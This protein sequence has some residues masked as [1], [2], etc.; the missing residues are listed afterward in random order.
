MEIYVDLRCFQD[1][2]YAFRGVGY[3]SSTLLREGRKFFPADTRWIGIVDSSLSDI[4][5]EYRDLVDELTSVASSEN[6]SAADVFIQLSPMTHSA[7]RVIRFLSRPE[8]LSAVVIYDFIPLDL[9]ERYLT[10]TRLATEYASNLGWLGKYDLMFPISEYSASR[11]MDLLGVDRRNVNVT[12]VALRQVFQAILENG[13]PDDE[14]AAAI[15]SP[16]FLF[17]GG[18]D[19]R[20]NVNVILKAHATLNVV[21][22]PRLVIVGA[23]PPRFHDEMLE[24]YRN[25]G[26]N[27]GDLDWKHGIADAELALLYRD[28]LCSICSSEIEGFSLPVI[29]AIASGACVFVSNIAAHRELVS[30]ADAIFEPHDSTRLG[31]LMQRAVDDKEWRQSVAK[32]QAPAAKR[33]LLERVSYRFWNPIVQR[34]KHVAKKNLQ[35]G[36]SRRARIAILSPFPPDRS[37]VADYTRS[38]LEEIGK[39]ADV[40][41]F[42]DTA[43]PIATSGVKRFIPLSA[44]RHLAG[45]Y[46]QIVSIVGNSHF[47]TKILEYQVEFG[48]PCLVHDNR[49]AEVYNWW[50]GPEAFHAMA[51]RSLGRAVTYDECQGWLREPGTLPSIFFDE[52][53]PNARPLMVHSRGLQAHIKKQYAAEAVYLPFCVY[54]QF[55]DH[56]LSLE[57]KKLARK[58]LGISDDVLAIITLGI[59]DPVKSP[60]TCIQAVSLARQSGLNAHLY[61]VG[62]SE[63][64]LKYIDECAKRWKVEGAIHLCGDWVDDAMYTDFIVAADMAIQLRK[65]FFGGLSGAMLDCIAS[66]L[67]TIANEDLAEA[68]EAP[69]NVLRISDELLADKLALQISNAKSKFDLNDRLTVMRSKYLVQHSFSE[70]AHQF[71]AA[72]RG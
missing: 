43:N 15:K 27:P 25:H 11:L 53:I 38:S 14:G 5:L 33:F 10:D 23:Y 30:V 24:I 47:H 7:E 40:D 2:G 8:T 66:G 51:C 12:G 3:H 31:Q 16:F 60:E 71:L 13:I 63:G 72:I 49:L 45:E 18:A 19:S 50:K 52:L 57:A 4:P 22:K 28:C 41:V 39:L 36:R 34:L 65:H 61:F 35:N 69:E 6:T 48:G 29:E 37:G 70:Y 46:D 62:S 26:G 55:P 68:L 44:V 42:C 54:R 58:K 59:V 20:K 56:L 17:V 9:Q 32:S 21:R 67:V 64:Q 1:A